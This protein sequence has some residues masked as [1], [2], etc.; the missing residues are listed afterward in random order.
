MGDDKMNKMNDDTVRA[1][2]PELTA[3][4]R[5][6]GRAVDA[7]GDNSAYED[8]RFVKWLEREA[9]E[10]M[11]PAERRENER[12]ANAFAARMEPQL[13]AIRVGE[14]LASSELKVRDAAIVGNIKHVADAAASAGCAPWLPDLA[15]AAGVGR[16][17][18][19][20]PCDRWIELPENIPDPLHGRYIALALAGDSMTPYL[21]NGDT[22]LVDTRAPVDRDT[23][24]VARRPEDG[25]V[26]KYVSRLT[27]VTMELSSFNAEYAPFTIARDRN[28]VVG[29]VAARLTRPDRS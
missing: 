20:E 18:W 14:A 25:Y 27:R 9:S 5:L 22:I 13:R 23:V 28:T 16:E 17:L 11:T 24:V 1:I 6:V 29:V 15:V 12:A 3:L 7:S 10:R 21:Q 2:D 4:E 19:D 26:V 8:E